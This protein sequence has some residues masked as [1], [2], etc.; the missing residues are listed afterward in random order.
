MRARPGLVNP[1]ECDGG[2]YDSDQVG[3]WSLWQ[4]NLGEDLM[5][6]GQDWGDTR[7]F[8]ANGGRDA[9]RNPTNENLRVLLLS[10][11]IEIPST[12][13]GDAGGNV[14]LTNAILCLKDGG[15]QGKVR[16]E[17]FANCGARFLQPT[18]DIIAPRVVA[19]LGEC[20]HRTVTAAYGARRT[21]SRKAVDRPGGLPARGRVRLRARVPLRRA[22]PEY[23]PADGHAETGLGA[24]G[25]GVAVDGPIRV[26]AGAHLP[27][28]ARTDTRRGIPDRCNK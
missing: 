25:E 2:I 23:A 3:P 12:A 21:A 13:P 22:D 16:P 7:Y 11:A 17:W 26:P 15:M 8:I 5:V 10:I 24:G 20:A 6:V 19:T 27:G 14:F 1:A 4:G 9:R 28:P 18:I